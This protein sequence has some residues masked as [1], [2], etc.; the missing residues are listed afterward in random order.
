MLIIFQINKINLINKKYSFQYTF[1]AIIRYCKKGQKK[2]RKM[3]Q[4]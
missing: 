1:P 3:K 2:M 4:K